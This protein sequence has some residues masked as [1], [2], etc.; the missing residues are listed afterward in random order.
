MRQDLDDLRVGYDTL[1]PVLDSKFDARLAV[2]GVP[3]FFQILRWTLT[4]TTTL[5][6]QIRLILTSTKQHGPVAQS[7]R[8]VH[9]LD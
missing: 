5:R 4:R 8:T 1:P 2:V 7:R 9:Q 3:L 6:L